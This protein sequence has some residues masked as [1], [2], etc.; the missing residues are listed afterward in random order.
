MCEVGQEA[1]H[2]PLGGIIQ[3]VVGKHPAADERQ[4]EEEDEIFQVRVAGFGWSCIKQ[5]HANLFDRPSSVHYTTAARG[6]RAARARRDT[7]QSPAEEKRGRN[8]CDDG[9]NRKVSEV[10]P[11]RRDPRVLQEQA[12]KGVDGVSKR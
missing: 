7:S 8:H 4:N 10:S 6:L 3:K 1:G 11:N 9:E 2:P 5:R 12:L